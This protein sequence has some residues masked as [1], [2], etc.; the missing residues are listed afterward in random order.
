MAYLTIKEYAKRWNV[1]YSLVAHAIHNGRLEAKQ[2]GAR[3]WRIDENEVIKPKPIE[4]QFPMSAGDFL[5][6]LA[7]I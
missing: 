3:M 4:P 5:T 2:L 1:S 7:T 6:R